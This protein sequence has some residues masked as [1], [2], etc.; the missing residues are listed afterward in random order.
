[1]QFSRPP[2][3]SSSLL[4]QSALLRLPKLVVASP[5]VWFCSLIFGW[6]ISTWGFTE[7]WHTSQNPQD[8]GQ[9]DCFTLQHA[10]FFFFFKWALQLPGWITHHTL[11]LWEDCWWAGRPFRKIVKWVK[12]F[13]SCPLSPCCFLSQ[14][15]VS[16]AL[17]TSILG[18]L[19]L[20]RPVLHHLHSLGAS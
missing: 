9:R 15:S 5:S 10:S 8:L 18:T 20:Y 11:R 2:L 19:A 6:K 14:T 17:P 12:S 7:C 4:P 1:M 13:F 3:T 16:S